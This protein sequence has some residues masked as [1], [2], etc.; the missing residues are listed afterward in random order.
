MFASKI[1]TRYA[2]TGQD[3]IIHHPSFAIYCEIARLEFFQQLGFDI[4]TLESQKTFCPVVALTIKYLKPL[5]SLQDVV[6]Q[7]AVEE[8]SKVRFTLKYLLLREETLVATGTTTHCFVNAA[9][10]P[11]AL[12][13]NLIHLL[14]DHLA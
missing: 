10:K 6:V 4:N 3:G 8:C 14:K 11:I 7:V 5:L 1:R 2:D 9:F 12:P 13:K